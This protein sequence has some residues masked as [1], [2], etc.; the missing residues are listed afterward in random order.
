MRRRCLRVWPVTNTSL[1]PSDL[2][3]LQPEV[4]SASILPPDRWSQG[5][6]A[7]S[8]DSEFPVLG[9]SARNQVEEDWSAAPARARKHRLEWVCRCSHHV[10]AT[11]LRHLGRV[12][13]EVDHPGG[14]PPKRPPPFEKPLDWSCPLKPTRNAD[15]HDG[16]Q[17]S[18]IPT[19]LLITVQAVPSPPF[20]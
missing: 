5:R 6:N 16:L 8:V 17:R 14:P 18:P 11:R 12:L 7:I 10:Q 20:S 13:H 19:K 1:A 4:A 9:A 3:R 2:A 15:Q